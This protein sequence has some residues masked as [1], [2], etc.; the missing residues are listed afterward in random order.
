MPGLIHISEALSIALHTCLWVGDGD[1]EYQPSPKIAK[2]L[3]FSY[4]HF[5]KVVQKLVH[6]GI[7]EAARGPHGGIRLACN[8]RELTM[9]DIYTA[10][11]GE[12]LLPHRCLL[13]PSICK[14]RACGLGQLFEEENQRLYT[15][16]N[17]TTLEALTHSLDKTK[18]EIA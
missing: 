12:P 17:T 14:G 16:M 3:G 11:G 13:D 1:K 15:K 9:L 10:A 7:L 5:A 18:L 4:H 6:G 8:P 2:E